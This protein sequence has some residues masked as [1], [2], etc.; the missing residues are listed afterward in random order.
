MD[1][2][3]RAALPR[4]HDLRVRAGADALVLT[5]PGSVNWVTGGVSDPVD[6]TAPRDVVWVVLTDETRALVTS[7]IEA[8]RL[9]RDFDVE[10]SGWD[11]VAVPWYRPE[12]MAEAVRSVAGAHARVISDDGE[13]GDDVREQIV[14]SRMV[15]SEPERDD[16]RELGR[17]VAGA[18]D[19]AVASWRPGASRDSE[20]ASEVARALIRVGALPVCLIVGGD[21]RLRRLRHPL[22]V[23]A[24]LHEAV[25]VVVVA[26]RGGLH[27][28]ATR[29]AVAREDDP[30][31]A[32]TEE[33]AV[34]DDAIRAACVPGN[35]WG[36]VVEALELGYRAMGHEG[37][38]AEHFQ[39]GPIAFDQRE[40]E[41]APGQISSP[42]WGQ[43]CE[44]GCAVAWNP[45]VSG[46]AKIEETYLVGESGLEPVTRGVREWER[47]KVVA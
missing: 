2:R 24:T 45:S 36:S 8:P 44:V 30:I 1:E 40:F 9:A 7:G 46:G 23:G 47:V 34:V 32:L 3:R 33:L 16:L 6:V 29:L 13:L 38:W 43:R 17:D 5:R 4:A 31:V 42:F 11:L 37:A 18:L 28:A 35:T 19:G 15:L 10:S 22:S 27:V 39:G 14:L 21:E 25:M 41:L 26:R 12:E 20:V